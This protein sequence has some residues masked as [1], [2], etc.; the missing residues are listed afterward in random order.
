MNALS[1]CLKTNNPCGTD[2]WQVGYYCPCEPCQSYLR[3]QESK[4]RLG[5]VIVDDIGR[6]M[7]ERKALGR[8]EME[9]MTRILAC[10]RQGHLRNPVGKC[11]RC[12]DQAEDDYGSV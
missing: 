7:E 9:S 11:V 6:R 1:R 3:I 4:R 5:A 8:L 10:K 12:Y 2:T